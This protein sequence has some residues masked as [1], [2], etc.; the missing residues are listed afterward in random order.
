MELAFLSLYLGWFLF[1][2]G[3]NTDY[4]DRK[5]SSELIIAG[6]LLMLVSLLYGFTL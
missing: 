6:G 2:V 1:I 4:N 5:T 3:C